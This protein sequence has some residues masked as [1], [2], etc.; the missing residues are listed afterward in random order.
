MIPQGTKNVNKLKI[1][2][3]L[4]ED[5]RERNGLIWLRTWTSAGS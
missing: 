2:E 5:G 4:Q 1:R 3:S